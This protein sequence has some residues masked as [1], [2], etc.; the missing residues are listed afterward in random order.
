MTAATWSASHSVVV[1]RDGRAALD[2]IRR[3]PPELL[4]LDVIDD[5]E[6]RRLAGVGATVRSLAGQT[7]RQITL[8][9]HDRTTIADSDPG[10]GELP[11][12]RPSSG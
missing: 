10:V 11:R 5:A 6:G 7:G 1:V 12:R 8:T 9:G 3:Q 4:V 2:E